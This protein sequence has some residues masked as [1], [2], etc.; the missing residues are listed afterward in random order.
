VFSQDALYL[1]KVNNL[2]NLKSHSESNLDQRFSTSS[3]N[4]YTN[5][6]QVILAEVIVGNE[7]YCSLKD[8]RNEISQKHDCVVSVDGQTWL[9]HLVDSI[10]AYPMYIIDF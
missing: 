9:W 8:L 6:K 4:D 7:F 1:S 2:S 3:G 10:R 5:S